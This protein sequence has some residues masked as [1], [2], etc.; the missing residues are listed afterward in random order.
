MPTANTNSTRIYPTF[1]DFLQ[2]E[3]TSLNGVSPEFAA[4]HPDY[5]AQNAT[6]TGC[7]DCSGCSDCSRCSGCSDC[8]DCY[9]C[10]YCS[11]C[12]RCSY[13]YG[14]YDCSGCSGLSNNAPRA[15]PAVPVIANIHQQVLA[16]VSKPG[17]LNMSS[18]HESEAVNEEGAYCGTTHCRA[19]WVVALAG[20]AGRDLEQRTSTLFAAMQIYRASAPGIPV[21]AASFYESN[22]LALADMRRCAELEQAERPA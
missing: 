15:L 9:D 8:Y 19:G 20:K 4:Q 14:C 6:N 3:D 11:D 13:C 18:W 2:R 17:A 22:D 12:S 21:S 16:A 10:S 5:A 7:Y 1:R